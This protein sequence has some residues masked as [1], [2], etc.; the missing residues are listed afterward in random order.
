[1]KHGLILAGGKGTRL[2]EITKGG[3]KAI[4]DINGRPFLSYLIE[5]LFSQGF[6]KIYVAAGYRA[7]DVRSYLD[8]EEKDVHLIVEDEPLGT[9]GAIYNAFRHMNTGTVLVING[10]TLNEADYLD[11]LNQHISSS[12]DISILTKYVDDVSRYG[13]I[14]LDQDQRI[15]DF[16]EKQNI[17]KS[18][19]VNVG[20][21]A[22]NKN[23]FSS[24]PNVRF[25]IE[26]FFQESVK[27]LRVNA[28]EST[29]EFIDIGIPDTYLAFVAKEKD[30]RGNDNN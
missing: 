7:A 21:Y 29:D 27:K 20:A 4:V 6:D 5:Q 22:I 28:V 26:D 19:Y 2:R 3:Q 13:E 10:D 23:V 30:R 1:M 12:A 17:K 14:I 15:V 16:R 18:G 8:A 9:G 25:S 24:V 11:F